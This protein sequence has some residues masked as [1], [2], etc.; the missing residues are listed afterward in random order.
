MPDTSDIDQAVIMK[1]ASDATLLGYMPNG[2]YFS[3]APPGSTRFV[4]VDY[5]TTDDVAMFGARSHEDKV[6]RILARGLSTTNPQM[7]E[8]AARIEALLEHA[9][10]TVPGYTTMVVERDES[11]RFDVIDEVDPKLRWFHRGGLYHVV[12]S[13]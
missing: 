4:T 6:Y 2:V 7:K 9:V 12:M 13:L 8:A 1:L 11:L 3:T 10:L 5:V